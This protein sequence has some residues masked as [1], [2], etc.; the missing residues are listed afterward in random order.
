MKVQRLLPACLTGAALLGVF[1]AC[2]VAAPARHVRELRASLDKTNSSIRVA[3]DAI[4]QTR[5]LERECAAIRAQ[6]AGRGD[7]KTSPLFWFP[8]QMSRYFR[9]FGVEDVTTRVNTGVPEPGLPNYQRTFWAV[10]LP[11]AANRADIDRALLALAELE[12]ADPLT[13]VHTLSA[14]ADSERRM[15]GGRTATI[16][17]SLLTRQF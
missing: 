4:Q 8:E 16:T 3:R 14:F 12:T 5:D 9:Q 11:L 7:S 17:V 2:G 1:Y 15:I 6:L 13:K 10:A